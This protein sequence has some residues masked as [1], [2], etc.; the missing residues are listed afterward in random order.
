MPN[1]F[2]LPKIYKWEELSTKID[3]VRYVQ[4]S[5]EAETL[6]YLAQ[7]APKPGIMLLGVGAAN[8][9]EVYVSQLDPV[10][11]AIVWTQLV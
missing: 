2:N 10:T 6:D 9:L 1:E 5:T 11:S 7:T 4:A 3:S 8:A